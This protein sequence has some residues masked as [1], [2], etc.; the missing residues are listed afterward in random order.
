M[1][2]ASRLGALLWGFFCL[3][4]LMALVVGVPVGLYVLAGWPLP[5]SLPTWDEVWRALSSNDVPESF[6]AHVIAVVGW[7]AWVYLV[8]AA[9]LEVVA[10]VRGV[11]APTVP[12]G[13][14]AQ[15]TVRRLIASVALVFSV[16]GPK[17]ATA[18]PLPPLPPPAAVV[19]TVEPVASVPNAPLPSAGPTCAVGPREDL[20]RIAERYLGDPGR[21]REVFALNVGRAQA[22]GGMLRE[23]DDD[24][25]P[26]WVLELPP[27]AVV[28]GAR[29]EVAET[30]GRSRAP[31]ATESSRTPPAV[32]LRP[33]P[34]RIAAELAE[35]AFEADP[36][37]RSEVAAHPL[38]PPAVLT[39]M[40][41]NERVGPVRAALS[42]NP[43]LPSACVEIFGTSAVESEREAAAVHPAAA[44][45]LLRFLAADPVHEVATAAR[46]RLASA[47]APV[48][49]R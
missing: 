48:P 12:F 24:L 37:V 21:W 18:A 35:Q 39:Y 28:R 36:G 1:R 14:W 7:L 49:G 34:G 4:V 22:D 45:E 42:S 13:G 33:S 32:G 15:W 2:T 10:R 47:V 20:W 6:Y 19:S 5:H 8:V 31:T 16:V 40:T 3:I 30:P 9:V 26:G 46:E 29:P 43:S 25:R 23:V 11:V 44:P 41:C 17:A 27:D 38:T